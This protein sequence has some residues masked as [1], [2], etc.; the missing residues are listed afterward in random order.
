M[1]L[2]IDLK[3]RVWDSIDGVDVIQCPAVDE[4]G[5]PILV[6]LDQPM[7]DLLG[8]ESVI[9]TSTDSIET[10]EGVEARI[11]N[12]VSVDGCGLQLRIHR[13]AIHK[14]ADASRLQAS[15]QEQSP[16]V[17]WDQGPTT[18]TPP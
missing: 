15:L 16:P 11:W 5:S 4:A 1:K 8:F 2:Q 10:L 17:L 13:V 7:G 12:A 14:D 18:I 3:R 9:A 6:F